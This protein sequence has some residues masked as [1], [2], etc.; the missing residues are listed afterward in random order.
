VLA[1]LGTALAR[2]NRVLLEAPPGAGKSTHVPLALLAAPWL[3]ARRILMLEPRR[4]A[5]RAVAQRMAHLLGE[6]LGER[7]GLRTRLETHVSRATRIEVVT[8]GVLTRLLQADAALEEFACVIFDEFHERSLHADL[9]LALCLESQQALR[10][11]LKLLVMSATLDV[12]P[13]VRLLGSPPIVTVEVPSFEVETHYVARRAELMLESQ[14]AQVVERAIRLHGGDVLCFLPGAAEIGRVQRQLADVLDTSAIELRPLYG[15]LSAAAQ[16]EALAATPVGRR[17]VVLATSIAETSLTLPGVRVVVDSGLRRYAE[18]DPATGMSRL[19][20]GKVSQAAADQRRGRAGRVS[21]GQCYRLWSQAIHATLPAHTSP[22][23]LHADLAALALELACWGTS[24]AAQLAWI[25]PP[26]PA[27]LAQARDL[28]ERLD[29]L[30][31]GGRITPLGRAMAGIGAHPRLAHMLKRAHE[32]GAAALACDLAALLGERDLLRG[33]PSARDADL[34]LRLQVLAGDPPPG[35][36]QV[37]ERTRAAVRRSAQSFGRALGEKAGG[38]TG[39]GDI[40]ALTGPLLALAYPDRVGQSRGGNGRYRLANGRGAHFAEPQALAR[41]EYLV[42]AELDGAERDA[43]IFLAAP[44]ERAELERLFA[45]R[46]RV[47]DSVEWDE[48][49]QAVRARRE[50]RLDALVLESEELRAA[51]DATAVARAALHG[52][53]RMGLAALPWTP[54]LEQFR[55]RI[56]LLRRLEV[57]APEP[58][59][60][61]SDATLLATLEEWAA[62]WMEGLTRAEHFA[63]FDLAAAL[64][65]RISHAQRVILDREAPTHFIVPSGSRIPIDYLEGDAPSLSVRLQEVFGLSSTP[66]VAAGSCPLLMKLLSP[67]GRPMQITRDLVSFWSRGYHEVRR[68]LKGRYPKHYWP[69]DPYTAQPTRRVRPR[70]SG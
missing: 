25:D 69:E 61:L 33:P 34:R 27:A 68:D 36:L 64:H 5:A 8:E 37:D 31:H 41:A 23:I 1:P 32:L 52:L 58:W 29:A 44:L 55:A 19:V 51:A 46:I 22:E 65:G 24:D 60:D 2:S 59:P 11:D 13:L 70:G 48:R 3:E 21:S 28:L 35:P 30:E 14:I 17:K 16:D 15:E 6:R 53:R 26:P 56:A 66:T 67:A 39:R 9:G 42:A 50:K 54:D 57:H 63:R 7:V 62:P 49:E 20:T 38:R 40:D 4:L 45:H 18:F 10:P 47:I 43:R 12:E